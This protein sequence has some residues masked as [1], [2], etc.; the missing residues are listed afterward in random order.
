MA[1]VACFLADV[2]MLKF[3]NSFGSSAQGFV[4]DVVNVLGSITSLFLSRFI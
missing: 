2:I 4:P 1:S 3:A